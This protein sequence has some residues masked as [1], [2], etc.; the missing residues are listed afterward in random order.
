MSRFPSHAQ[1]VIIGGG[2]VGASVAYHLTKLGYRD[3]VVL[4][5]NA[6]GSGTTWHSAAGLAATGESPAFLRNFRYS[7]SEIETIENES[8]LSVGRKVVGRLIFSHDEK[9]MTRMRRISAHGRSADFALEVLTA[10]ETLDLLPIL[11][12]EGLLGGL[13]NPDAYRVDP[14]G[15]TEALFRVARSRGAKVFENARVTSIASDSC[16]RAVTTAGGAISC[17]LI[18]NCAGIWA[19]E[20][21][22][23]V[24]LSLPIVANEHFYVLTK[25]IDGMP[26]DIPSFRA[27]DGLFYGREEVGGLLLGVFDEKAR[28][29]NVSDLPNDFAFGLLPERWEQLTPYVDDIVGKLPIFSKA[30][31]KT[32]INGPEAFTP[33]HRYILGESDR[34]KGFY[35]LAGMNSSGVGFS[36]MA[37]RQL[38]EVIVQG[39]PTEDLTDVDICRFQEFERSDEWLRLVGPDLTSTTYCF[40]RPGSIPS[41]RDVRLSPV[42]SLLHAQNANF[43]PVCGW[44]VATSF[45]NPDTDPI[46]AEVSLLDS[47]AGL[48]DQSY[49]GKIHL[50]G[51]GATEALRKVAAE[52]LPEI[53]NTGKRL[54]IV[55]TRGGVESMPAALP[56]GED[57]W[58]LLVEPAETPRLRR[59]L[60]FVAVQSRVTEETSAWAQFLIAG[61]A[62]DK[63]IRAFEGLDDTTRTGTGYIGVTPVIVSPIGTEFVILCATE[64]AVTLYKHIMELVKV[65]VP[66]FAPVG[67]SAIERLRIA[68]GV[69]R[70]GRDVNAHLPAVLGEADIDSHATKIMAFRTTGAMP[71]DPQVHA[72]IWSDN[73][74]VGYVT[75]IGKAPDGHSVT[76]IARIFGSLG[77]E[78]WIDTG[79]G[80]ARL[81]RYSAEAAGTQNPQKPR[82]SPR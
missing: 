53:G 77:R 35:T 56:L 2:V 60:S 63:V 29:I 11:S 9:S 31:I 38:A 10:A 33:D 72:P 42:H 22:A 18:V 24:N 26:T 27:G 34:V 49:F 3:I 19:R 36:L 61:A 51:S 76:A 23:M 69:A 78:I 32:F 80:M 37:G 65:A 4:E 21:A 13:W 5:R 79:A 39:A 17:E 44:E 8:G 7:R 64:Y 43:E 12:P 25:P 55:S 16:V 62:A 71:V 74:C 28:V 66:Q 46:S 57:D 14:T 40:A 58:L 1:V 68:R 70:W 6:I 45:G 81:E 52:S 67:S 30:E 75:S 41:V 73:A 48:I 50:S 54:A 59:F 20:V 47:A 15:F 82:S